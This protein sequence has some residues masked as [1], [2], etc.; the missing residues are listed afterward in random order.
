MTSLLLVLSDFQLYMNQSLKRPSI[1]FPLF[2]WETPWLS[3]TSLVPQERC[4]CMCSLSAATSTVLQTIQRLWHQKH[5][6]VGSPAAIQNSNQS[7]DMRFPNSA[8]LLPCTAP[9]QHTGGWQLCRTNRLS[10]LHLQPLASQRQSQPKQ[11]NTK[12]WLKAEAQQHKH[13]HRAAAK[14]QLINVP[15]E[16][17][18]AEQQL[19]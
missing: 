11:L 1:I 6:A 18:G 14:P 7:S 4:S 13:T 2:P 12:A 3:K 15:A 16:H 19:Y 17:G 5:A 8:M 10:P 9:P